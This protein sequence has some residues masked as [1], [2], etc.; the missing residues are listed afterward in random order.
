MDYSKVKENIEA[1]EASDFAYAK[2]YEK[3]PVE[4]KV[5][6][7]ASGYRFVANHIRQT[8]L[9]INPFATQASIR[10][11]FIEHTQKE[12]YSEEVYAFIEEKMKVYSEKEWQERFKVMKK[13]LGWSYKE[14]AIYMEAK[15]G[16]SIKASINRQLPAFA[17]LAVCIFEQNQKQ[18]TIE[19][20]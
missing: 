8:V 7:I 5:S 20:T 17:K 1:S 14:M 11:K 4:R 18:N 3:Q 19:K 9:K 16:S 15:N 6:M 2:W 12:D 13:S 10:A